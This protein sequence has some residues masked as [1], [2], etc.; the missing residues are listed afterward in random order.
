MSKKTYSP[1]YIDGEKTNRKIQTVEYFYSKDKKLTEEKITTT[2]DSLPEKQEIKIIKYF[3][4][5]IGDLIKKTVYVQGEENL[6]GKNIEEWIYDDKGNLTKTFRYNSL[7]STSKYCEEYTYDKK[8]KVSAERSQT[9]E[10]ETEFI[11]SG[12]KMTEQKLPNGS[13]FAFGYDEN[14]RVNSVSHSTDSGEANSTEKVYNNG[15]L[16][17]LSSGN[18]KVEYSYDNKR[19]LISIGLN[20]TENYAVTN[21]Q[22]NLILDGKTVDKTTTTNAKGESESVVVD[23]KGNVLK[24]E[25]NGNTK[26]TFVYNENNMLSSKQDFVTGETH[27]YVYD[28]KFA[29][30]EHNFG[31]YSTQKTFDLYHNLTALDFKKNNTPLL[32]YQYAYT[33]DSKKRRKSTTVAGISESYEYDALGRVK[34]TVTTAGESSFAKVRNFQKV[35]D[36]TTDRVVALYYLKNGVSDTKFTYTYDNMG[37]VI[38]ISENGVQKSKYEYDLLNRLVKET[39]IA[40]GIEICYTIDNEGNILTKSTNGER[41]EYKYLDGSDKLVS[42]GGENFVYDAIGN[43]TTYRNK[44]LSWENGR[45]LKSYQDGENL[46][47]YTY[48]S[49]SFR[50]TKTVNGQTTTYV[51]ENGKLLREERAS[52]SIDYLYGADGIIGIKVNETVYLFRKNIFGDVTEIYDTN[53]A[54]IGKYSY[55]AYGECSIDLQENSVVSINPIRYRS[56]YYDSETNLYYL[57]SRYYDPETGRF[58][59]IDD[60]SYIMPDEVNGLNLYAYCADNPVMNV[61]PNGTFLLGLVVGLV[62]GALVVGVISDNIETNDVEMIH[63]TD[64]LIED[65]VV[66]TLIGNVS[67]TVTQSN[68]EEADIYSY[69]DVGNDGVNHGIG[70]KHKDLYGVN[71]YTNENGVGINIQLFGKTEIGMEIGKKGITLSK[72][73]V[74]KT[75]TGTASINIGWLSL[76]IMLATM[77]VPSLAIVTG[78]LAIA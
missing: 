71:I 11:Y 19:R 25:R 28:Q 73:T 44:T 39:D 2:Y 35:G 23:K 56:Y 42:F 27:N 48:D 66:E 9:G 15:M 63:H 17:M 10:S 21:H 67:Y 70:V 29:E 62:V 3:Y 55:T 53:G 78:A 69:T 64:S 47:T 12:D 34:K 14:G 54:L 75:A 41:K 65:E 49:N 59:T 76:G 57:K 16:T 32:T 20:G 37:N 1:I 4:N 6:Y 77:G 5:Q 50:K 52:Q 46:Y 60:T 18:N 51:Y 40:K 68:E 43:P 31:A 38:S 36:H 72:G 58:I 30:K 26:A 24:Q 74:K 45:E 22:D 13:K 8:G 61:D 7:D 33:D